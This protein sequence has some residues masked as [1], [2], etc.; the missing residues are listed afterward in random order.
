[1]VPE[2]WFFRD[3]T[4]FRCLAQRL[5]TV[6]FAH[7]GHDAGPERRLQHGRRGLLPGDGH[8]RGRIRAGRILVLGTDVS[9][10]SLDL[11]A[12]GTYSRRGRSGNTDETIAAICERWCERVGESWQVRDE[13]RAGMEFRWGNLA[14]ADFLA[15][16]PPFDVIFCRNVLI[17]FHAEAR[18]TAIASPATA[19]G[20]GGVLCARRRPSP[21]LQRGRVPQSRQ[22]VSLR[23]PSR[24]ELQSAIAAAAR[25]RRERDRAS[26]PS[27]P[28][29]RA[30]AGSESSRPFIDHPLPPTDRRQTRAEPPLPTDREGSLPATPSCAPPKQ[31]ADDGRL[32]EAD[33]LCG[34]C[35][36]RDPAS[37][38]AH[39]LRG[40]VRQAQGVLGEAQRSLEKALYLDPKHYQ[41]LVHMMLLAEQR[42]DR[43]AAANYRRR[44]QQAAP[45]EVDVM[46][47][48][49]RTDNVERRRLPMRAGAASACRA[50]ARARSSP[51]PSIAATVRSSR[52]PARQL[53]ERE[54]PPEY[55]DECTRQL[56][57]VEEAAA[58]ETLSLLVFRIGPEWLALDAACGCRGRRAAADPSRSAP[59]EPASCWAWPTSAASCTSASRCASCWGSTRPQPSATPTSAAPLGSR[60]R[61]LVAEHGQDRWVFPVDEVEGVHRVPAAAMENLP[62]TVQ[63]SPRYYSQAVFSHGS[64]RVGM[65][66]ATGCSRHWRGPSDESARRR[67]FPDRLVPRRSPH[68][69]P[70]PHRR[71]GGAGARRRE[72]AAARSIDARRPFDQGRGAR[73]ERAAGRRSLARHGRL[74]RPGTEGRIDADQRSGGR[75]AGRAWT[76]CRE[77]REAAGAGFAAWLEANQGHVA[78]LVQRLDSV[79]RQGHAGGVPG[80][81]PCWASQ[82]A[83]ADARNMH[84][85]ARPHVAAV[86][87]AGTPLKPEA[88]RWTA[89][90]AAKPTKASFASRPGA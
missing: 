66:S 29:R 56:A 70:G 64:K 84:D 12:E 20:P 43:Q 69:L 87:C 55:L 30:I 42:G 8:A 45:P 88:R 65:L 17:Y 81:S 90:A 60:P 24:E 11:R 32:D 80:A 83:A 7:R 5:E 53:F 18:R 44:A 47:S 25:C 76:C 1:M 50:T 40:V 15:G 46:R 34:Q 75:S 9:R 26:L 86:R 48:D 38:A 31:A 19:V 22:R 14:Q 57:E 82:A 13:L 16:E 41:A 33:A 68:E 2:T 67:R 63:R 62:H 85:S 36:S 73:G 79:V 27:W 89:H 23:L 58:A 21:D 74:F 3:A 4:G 78:G 59:H 39:Y 10:R 54:A 72:P 52:P 49:K 28:R 35:L 51:R 37:A 77:S 61:L 6:A 71:T